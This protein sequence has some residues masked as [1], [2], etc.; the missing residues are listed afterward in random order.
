[1]TTRENLQ[2]QYYQIAEKTLVGLTDSIV[3]DFVFGKRIRDTRKLSLLHDLQFYFDIIEQQIEVDVTNNVFSGISYYKT[4]F[5]TDKIKKQLRC[6]GIDNN[7]LSQLFNLYLQQALFGSGIG[8][9]IIQGAVNPFHI[10]PSGVGGVGYN[11][12]LNPVP[13]PSPYPPY[14]VPQPTCGYDIIVVRTNISQDTTF[15]N[16]LPANCQFVNL[17][18]KNLTANVAQLSMGIT[19]G[20]V[21]CFGSWGLSPSGITTVPVIKTFSTTLPTTLYLNHASIGDDWGGAIFDLTF[22]FKK[23]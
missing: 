9:M 11:I 16:L 15:T 8:S 18:F 23:L 20:G 22:W 3:S 19:A 17:T 7:I 2:M 12:T 5:C 13:S 4:L 21:E 14:P 1:M 6:V 10:R